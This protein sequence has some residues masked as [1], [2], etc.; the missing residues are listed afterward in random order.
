M[1][2]AE[3]EKGEYKELTERQE[4]RVST[5]SSGDDGAQSQGSGFDGLLDSDLYS[6]YGSGARFLKIHQK[7][8][9]GRHV[10]IIVVVDQHL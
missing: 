7:S 1:E 5:Y 8:Q 4:A 2:K 3:R 6:E 9:K 10:H